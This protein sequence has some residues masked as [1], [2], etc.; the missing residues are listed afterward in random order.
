MS[1]KRTYPRRRLNDRLDIIDTRS[2][3]ILGNLINISKGGFMLLSNV[4]IPTHQL[5]QLRLPLTTPVNGI[6]SIDIGATCLWCQETGQSGRSWI[7]FQI[8]DI[9]EQNSKIIETLIEDWQEK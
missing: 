2:D 6:E 4:Q 5:Y 9:S 1:D 7:G 3:Q 8:I